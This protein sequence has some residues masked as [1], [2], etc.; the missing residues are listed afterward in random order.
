[1]NGPITAVWPGALSARR[2]LGR[3]RASTSRSSRSMPKGVELCL[4]DADGPARDR[5]ASRLPSTPTRS[6][7]AICPKRGPGQLYGY[8]VHGPYEPER[9]APL[10]PAQAAARSL[11]EGDRRRRCAGATRCSATA[12]GQP[13][14]RISRFDHRDSAR[15]HAELQVVDAAF[16][17]ATTARPHVPWHDTVIY[18]L[19][20]RGF[21][22]LHPDVPPQLRGTYAGL[23]HRAPVIDYLKRSASPT[24]ELLPVHT[25]VDDRH[26][27]EHGPA[28]LLGLQHD[29]LLR[30]RRRAISAVA[31][32]VSE[33]KT[34]V[35]TLHAAGI[36]VILDVVYNHTAEG[37]QIGP[38]AVASAAST[39][40]SYYRLQPDDAALLRGLHRLRQHAQH[41]APARAA[42]GHGLAAL[43]GHARCT[44]TASA[45][46]SPPRWRASCTTV[47]RLGAFF[48]IAPP[49]SGALAGQADRRAVGRRRRRLPGRQLSRRLGRVERP[50]SRHGARA[51]GRATAALIGDFAS[52]LTGSRDL[53]G[54]QRPAAVRQHQ[55]RH[56][57]R[58]LHAA[59]PGQLQREAQRGQRRGQPR[60]QQ[61]Q[62]FAGTAASRARPT[63]RRSTRCARA[64]SATSWRRCCSRRA[65]RCSRPATR[66]AARQRG[67]N[68]A[69]CQDNEISWLDWKLDD[70]PKRAL[71]ALH[72]PC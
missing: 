11:R 52:R 46:I 61:P 2:D 9:R 66:S 23:A 27:V 6:G 36:E 38:D 8:R 26:L 32:T 49:G 50:V 67:N 12:I 30:A 47:D 4:F 14:A 31:A 59:R 69:Y 51:S 7:I 44:S 45:S 70:D 3:R 62:P 25:F 24:V 35:K 56:R 39:T 22:M 54:Q 60:R 1:M 29:R 13:S 40:P 17:G 41:A 55:L 57:A 63:T 68:N 65:C 53:Y 15:R 21:T 43:L 37:N 34:M 18:E 5:S 16:T 20:V 71:L 10:Q 19:H 58:R 33:F 28:Q 42:A 72:A 64:R 48:D